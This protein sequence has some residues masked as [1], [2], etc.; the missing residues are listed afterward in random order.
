M[1]TFTLTAKLA[2]MHIL[3][4]MTTDTGTGQR[5]LA[6]HGLCM[7]RTA[8]KALVL[9]VQSEM[10]LPVMIEAPLLPVAGVVA[11]LA[12]RTEVQL[13][14]VVLTVARNAFRLCVLEL[15]R[16]VAF[17]ALDLQVPAQQRKTRERMIEA[18]I[19]TSP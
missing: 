17:P 16:E 6:R 8:F 18:R 13:V 10:R 4:F 3:V 19:L 1:T 12:L 2:E 5:N 9:A 11:G 14:R 15:R 7:A